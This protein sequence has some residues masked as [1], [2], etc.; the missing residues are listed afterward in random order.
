MFTLWQATSAVLHTGHGGAMVGHHPWR[1]QLRRRL[2]SSPLQAG[3]FD[4]LARRDQC[5]QPISDG[6]SS[7]WVGVV[8][9]GQV[10]GHRSLD[11]ARRFVHPEMSEHQTD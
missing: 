5:R 8:P 1:R 11:P 10:E 2:A 4:P 9:G 3:A 7:A 6:L